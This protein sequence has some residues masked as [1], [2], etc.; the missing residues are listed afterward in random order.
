METVFPFSAIVGQQSMLTALLLNAVDPAI[1]GVLIQGGKGSGKST[2]ARALASLLPPITVIEDCSMNSAPDSLRE[3]HPRYHER[4]RAGE[5]FA[6]R[7]VEAPFVELP[8]NATEDRVAGTLRVE[9]ALREGRREFEPGL[10]AAAHRGVLYVDEVNLLEDHLVDLLLDAASSGINRVEREGISELHPSRFILIGTMNPEEGELRPQFLDRFALTVE[11]DELEGREQRAEI[12]EHAMKFEEDPAAFR[13]CFEAEELRL[14]NLIS[15]ARRR[16]PVVELPDECRKRAA[17]ICLRA[18]VP[19]HRGDI[20]VV[21]TAR[22]E[23][24]LMEEER[25]QLRHIIDAA[26]Y[27]LP[28]RMYGH[29]GGGGEAVPKRLGRVIQEAVENAENRP[30]GSA[31]GGNARERI[32][33]DTAADGE[34]YAAEESPE[35]PGAA[36]AGSIVFEFIKKKLLR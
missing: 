18:R 20:A 24:A 5:T 19:G 22:A 7:Q 11:A 21:R 33:R 1:G 13:R 31:A 3:M 10:L 9:K 30:A 6:T 15:A 29:D 26:Y 27:V 28:H 12:I 16:L 32:G 34:E 23:A 25:V 4:Y 17:D 2:A 8:L 14:R 36:A 35:V